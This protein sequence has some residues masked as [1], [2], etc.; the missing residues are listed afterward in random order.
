M[1]NHTIPALGDLR[2]CVFAAPGCMVTSTVRDMEEARNVSEF[3]TSANT[4]ARAHQVG[5]VFPTDAFIERYDE[6]G[7]HLADLPDAVDLTELA[8]STG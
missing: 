5:G 8:R 4:I 7:W 2:V 3:M 1:T 6:T